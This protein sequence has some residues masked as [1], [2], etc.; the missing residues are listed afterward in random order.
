MTVNT[1]GNLQQD[2]DDLIERLVED[3][4]LLDQYEQR[5]NWD[6][7]SASYI[8]DIKDA[9]T[10]LREQEELGTVNDH[11]NFTIEKMEGRIAELE[12]ENRQLRWDLNEGYTGFEAR[13]GDE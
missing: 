8:A 4:E 13:A 5:G 10:A 12:D 7:R 9:I 1:L 2:K 6:F 11:L 3:C